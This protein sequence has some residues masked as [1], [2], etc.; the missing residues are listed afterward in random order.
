MEH[1]QKGTWLVGSLDNAAEAVYLV[2]LTSY[3]EATARAD[4]FDNAQRG[5]PLELQDQDLWREQDNA[6]H[7]VDQ[8][9]RNLIETAPNSST[10]WWPGAWLGLSEHTRFGYSGQPGQI[11]GTNVWPTEEAAHAGR[12]QWVPAEKWTVTWTPIARTAFGV[13]PLDRAYW[14]EHPGTPT[15]APE[16]GQAGE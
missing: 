7:V 4:R 12:P 1:D 14:A 16:S 13:V 2:A 9:R 15:S 5:R 11:D 6:W 3:Q 8:W 10:S